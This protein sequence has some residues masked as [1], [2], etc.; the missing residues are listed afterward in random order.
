R[1]TDDQPKGG[2]GEPRPRPGEPDPQ[3]RHDHGL[4]CEQRPLAERA[5]LRK[6][7]VADSR[8]PGENEIDPRHQR[9]LVAAAELEH[10]HEPKL[11]RLIDDAGHR[12][13]REPER[14]Q[15]SPTIAPTR[16]FLPR[17]RH[18]GPRPIPLPCAWLPIPAMP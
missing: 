6:Q 12:G 1:P 11:H 10:I 18:A 7:A 4:E 13:Y 3:E 5:L 2:G 9:H 15:E 14:A 8:V 17:T 16:A